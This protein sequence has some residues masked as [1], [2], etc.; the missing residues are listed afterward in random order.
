MTDFTND[1]K[2][3]LVAYWLLVGVFMIFVQIVIGGVTRLTGSGLSI[4]EWQPILGVI[5]PMNEQEWLLAFE[6]Y[7]GIAQFKHV[8]FDFTLSDFKFIYFWEWFHR[9]WARA[10]GIVFAIPFIYFIVKK[11]FTARMIF[12]LLLL[13]VLGG[14]QGLIG[15][16]MVQ[17]GLNDTNLY[18]SHIR[19]AIHFMSALVLLVYTF[20]FALKLLVPKGQ[21]IASTKL[22]ALF[23]GILVILTIQLIYGA[24]MAGLHAGAAAPTWPDM[25]GRFAPPTLSTESWINERLNIQFIHRTLA[26]ILL[27]L[28]AFAAFELRKLT[29]LNKN[30]VL[31]K[32]SLIWPVVFVVIQIVLGVFAVLTSVTIVK[33][34]FGTYEL[35][36]ELHQI[37][38]LFLLLSLIY[39]YYIIGV[40]AKA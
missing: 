4:T 15:W 6:K 11:Y 36:A 30:L 32:K 5:P 7:Q 23:L 22:K 18:V 16:I 40:R 9:I 12:P 31:L 34:H 14:L 37:V 1:K 3:K 39:I 10:L 28:L 8:N 24:F 20:W 33:G 13:F 26:Y 17:S 21:R 38:A 27:L 29:Q 2:R 19:L 35:I 25:N